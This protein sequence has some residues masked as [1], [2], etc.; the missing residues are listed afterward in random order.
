MR[1]YYLHVIT[2]AA[3]LDN[4]RDKPLDSPPLPSH[5]LSHVS[6]GSVLYFTR[7]DT[8][9]CPSGRVD[10]RTADV[11]PLSNHSIIPVLLIRSS[12]HVC[13]ARQ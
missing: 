9:L 2:G 10:L 5:V 1:L 11:L 7:R 8:V 4:I 13:E 6:H 12:N 3:K